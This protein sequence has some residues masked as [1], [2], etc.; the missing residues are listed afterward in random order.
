MTKFASLPAI[1]VSLV[2]NL[3]MLIPLGFVAMSAESSEPVAEITSLVDEAGQEELSFE[4]II[5]TSSSSAQGDGTSDGAGLAGGTLVA[6]AD[7]AGTGPSIND[8]IEAVVIPDAPRIAAA[9]PLPSDAKLTAKVAVRG[10]SDKVVG[11]VQGTMDR[12]THEIRQ[13]LEERQTLVMWMFDA[14]GSLKDRRNA[15]TERFENIYRQLSDGGPT[16]GLYT[17]VVSYGEKTELI[18]QDPVKDIAS[19]IQPIRHMKVDESGIENVFTA[20]RLAADKWKQFK[21]TEGKWNKVMFIVTDER[22][23]DAE[24][25]LEDVISLCKRSGIRVYVVGNAAVFGQKLGYVRWK[26]PDGF[27]EDIEVDQGPESAFPEG[28]QLP[29][30]GGGDW[31]TG[32]IS[33]SYGPYALTRL[34]A[35]TGGMYLITDDTH[36]RKYDAA[37]MREYA[38]DYRPVRI[39]ETEISKNAAKV[40]LVKAAEMTLQGERFEVPQLNFPAESDA[41][42]REEINKAQMPVAKVFYRIDELFKVLKDAEKARNT[43]KEPRWRASFDLAMGRLLAMH[44]RFDGYNRM[45]ADMKSTPKTFKDPKNNLW[46]LSPSKDIDV[47]KVGPLVKQRGD[48][49]KVYLSRVIDEHPG[50]P[51]ADLAARELRT[52]L[53][54]TWQEDFRDPTGQGRTAQQAANNTPRLLLADENKPQQMQRPKEEKERVKPKL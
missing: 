37:V 7:A 49:A 41:K 48:A 10:T 11:G 50:T 21:R 22:G 18:T 15:I 4:A 6:A 5:P 51:W 44:A 34:C 26:Y 30:W 42:L 38:P 47:A 3:S 39:Q 19:I 32:R 28:L 1:G 23:D 17:A 45:L 20:V 25:Q 9:I 2:V 14:S 24:S 54:W 35:E 29:N 33:A 13:S 46:R 53:G 27:E 40:A 52:E 16:D 36:Q 12:I 8:R 31:R 43:I